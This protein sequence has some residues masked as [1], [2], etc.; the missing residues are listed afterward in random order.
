MASNGEVETSA[1]DNI[2]PRPD[3][4]GSS[5]NNYD[6]CVWHNLNKTVFT[7]TADTAKHLLLSV[8]SRCI[9]RIFCG[10][11]TIRQFSPDL[12]VLLLLLLLRNYGA[13]NCRR[14]HAYTVTLS[15]C[16]S[17]WRH[18]ELVSAKRCGCILFHPSIGKEYNGIKQ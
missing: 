2:R 5:S 8:Y 18:I 11:S 7:F 3:N 15:V 12:L 16:S 10:K 1:T 4:P 13:Q 9:L 17:T 6:A 14:L